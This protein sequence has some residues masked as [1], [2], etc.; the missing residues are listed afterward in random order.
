MLLGLELESQGCIPCGRELNSGP[1]KQQPPLATEPS[2]L[3]LALEL[4]GLARL[5]EGKPPGSPVPVFPGLRLQVGVTIPWGVCVCVCVCV[6]MNSHIYIF[7]R[8]FHI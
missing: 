3:P 6:Y 4:V 8:P 7:E 2:L 5:A 1:L